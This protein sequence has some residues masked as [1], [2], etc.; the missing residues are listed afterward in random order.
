MIPHATAAGGWIGR[1][2]GRAAVF[3]LPAGTP[4]RPTAAVPSCDSDNGGIT[5]PDGFC[6]VVVAD[7]VGRARHLAVTPSGDIFVALD[8]RRGVKGGVLAL[9]DTSGDGK[10][11]ARETAGTES[12]T[13]IALS[14]G[15]LYFSTATTAHR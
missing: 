11:D 3:L 2:A 1:P 4:D 12:G 9:R 7:Q 15:P 8:D 5:L 13:G 6:A 14:K 10:A